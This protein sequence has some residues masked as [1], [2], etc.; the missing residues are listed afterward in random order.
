MTRPD[1]DVTSEQAQKAAP[2][3]YDPP[4]M[5][6]GPLHY[7]VEVEIEEP[8]IEDEEMQP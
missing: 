5:Y 6:A 7:F 1:D 2:P 3:E 4:A 8:Q